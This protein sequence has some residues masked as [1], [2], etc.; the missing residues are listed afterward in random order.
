MS[1]EDLAALLRGCL[2]RYIELIEHEGRPPH[3]AG[4]IAVEEAL[5]AAELLLCTWTLTAPELTAEQ[6][7]ARPF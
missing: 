3:Q 5:D 7:E 4:P 2:S 6:L 1:R